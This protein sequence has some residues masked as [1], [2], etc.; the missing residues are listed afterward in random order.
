MAKVRIYSCIIKYHIPIHR[1]PHCCLWC[2]TTSNEMKTSPYN[3]QKPLIPIMNYKALVEMSP[4]IQAMRLKLLRYKLTAVH[5]PGKDL[6]DAD[7]FSR[8]ATELPT[9]ED[10]KLNKEIAEHVFSVIQAMPITDARIKV[11]VK[12]TK[13]DPQLHQL[14]GY[15]VRAVYGMRAISDGHKELE[16]FC[17]YMNI[18]VSMNIRAFDNLSGHLR[19]AVRSTS[20]R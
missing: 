11:I 7:C 12:K 15:N 3:D 16:K 9:K 1:T 10:E 14:I 19:D 2:E 20:R 6:K 18:S 17:I 13:E 5:I 4:R 8:A